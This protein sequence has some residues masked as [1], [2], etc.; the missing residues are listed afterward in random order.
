MSLWSYISGTTDQT[1]Q[2]A[3]FAAK[4]QALA[5][6]NAAHP[7]NGDPVHDAIVAQ[8][9][10]LQSE[11]LDS[12]GFLNSY[13]TRDVNT[14]AKPGAGDLLLHLGIVV[15]LVGGAWAFFAFGGYLLVREAIAGKKW[16][17]VGAAAL[18]MTLWAY[19]LFK[20]GKLAASDAKSITTESLNL[21]SF[22]K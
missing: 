15:A 4:Q 22:L 16:T 18:V 21:F 3:Q 10:K 9:Q 14:E 1:E 2:D 19:L 8:N 5:E 20:Y 6:A 11:T 17:I 7:A 13:E 12:S